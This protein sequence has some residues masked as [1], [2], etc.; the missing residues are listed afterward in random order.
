MS[1]LNFL[2]GCF[3]QT[4]RN[5]G[6]LIK[7]SRVNGLLIQPKKSMILSDKKSMMNAK[8]WTKSDKDHY[9]YGVNSQVKSICT[10][11]TQICLEA[12]KVET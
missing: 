2:W 7:S 5:A 3:I 8:D 11:K 6:L 9:C 1:S 12:K 10:H 4:L